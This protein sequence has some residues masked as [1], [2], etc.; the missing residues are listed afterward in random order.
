MATPNTVPDVWSLAHGL[1]DA[2]HELAKAA[3]VSP[4]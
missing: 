2:L 1:T 3:A 4:G